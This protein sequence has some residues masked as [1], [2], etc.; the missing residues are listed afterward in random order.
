MKRIGKGAV[1]LCGVVLVSALRA[2]PAETNYCYNSDFTSAKGPLDG[3]NIDYDWTLIKKQTGNAKNASVLPMFRAKE[4]VLKMA[5][6]S[7]YETKVET[8]LIPYEPGDRYQC[9][10]DILVENNLEVHILFLGYNLKPGISPNEPPKLQNLRRVYK[11]EYVAA[12]GAAWKTMRVTIPNET[13]SPVAYSH[14]KKVR[15][16]TVFMFVPGST[17]LRDGNFY[18]SNL[19][20]VKLPEKVKVTK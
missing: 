18:V 5:V 20:I 7:G 9:T 10:F 4:R 12:T 2:A 8:P 17:Y 13:I 1:W 15:Y 3:W 6:P 14:L 11:A 19:K 16:I